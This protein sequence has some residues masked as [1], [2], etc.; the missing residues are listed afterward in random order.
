[1]VDIH[2]D[3]FAAGYHLGGLYQVSSA[4]RFGIDYKSR[5]GYNVQGKQTVFQPSAVRANVF[6]SDVLSGLNGDATT[7]VTLPDV[8][9]MSGYYDINPAWAVMGTVQWTHWSLLQDIVIDVYNPVAHKPLAPELTP[10]GFNSTWMESVGVNWRPP[11]LPRLMLQAGILYDQ[12]ANDDATRGARVPDENR[13]GPA[14]GFSYDITPRIR[15][16]AA[17][18]HEFPTGGNRVAYSNNFPNAG[19]LVGKYIDNADVVS[20]GLTMKF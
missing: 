13:V 3:A 16:R 2:G 8:L 14:G 20:A 17:Y 10:V 19:T 11:V 1:V 7:Q 4:L 9:T 15:L 6:I 12:G 18:L 5:L